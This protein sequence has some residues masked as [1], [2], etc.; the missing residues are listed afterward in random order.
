MLIANPLFAGTASGTAIHGSSLSA[1]SHGNYVVFAG[2]SNTF[3]GY[4][5]RWSGVG[6]FARSNASGLTASTGTLTLYDDST[7]TW[8][9]FGDTV[10]AR[11]DV[12]QG[13]V[14]LESGSANKG[15]CLNIT[16]TWAATGT[17]LGLDVP[18][19]IAASDYIG[20]NDRC[21]CLFGQLLSGQAFIPAANFGVD[22]DISYTL[23]ERIGQVFTVDSF[24]R[25]T[26]RRPRVVGVL[27]GINDVTYLAG[28]GLEYDMDD[29]KGWVTDIKD[30]IISNGG[31]AAFGNLVKESPSAGE[32]ALIAEFNLHLA[33]LAA[34]DPDNVKVA[35]YHT[36]CNG[37]AGAMD[38]VHFTNL[39]AK[40]AGEQMAVILESLAGG[41]GVSDFRLGSGAQNLITNG[42]MAGTSGSKGEALTGVTAVDAGFTVSG[43]GAAVGSKEAVTGEY[44]WQVYTI[45][46]ADTGDE[47]T[48]LLNPLWAIGDNIYGEME[49]EITGDGVKAANVA[50]IFLSVDFSQIEGCNSLFNS[51]NTD[52]G[53]LSGVWRTAPIDVPSFY[54][55]GSLYAHFILSAGDTVIKVRNAGVG[56]FH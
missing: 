25:P 9:A 4:K 8:T 15:I 6:V 26:S 33:T 24:G 45:T 21:P 32:I 54:D 37:V 52:M 7:A 35:D 34:A 10:G 18:I 13:L 22:G 56:I 46:G 11:I 2:D 50:T 48:V 20:G 28:G 16:A 5:P 1:S 30:S 3:Y 51:S 14:W 31:V 47:L 17:A 53:E 39:G 49:I 41:A 27:I 42:N 29:V 36:A 55:T 12:G 44:D 40:L 43:A 23:L 38:G 19:E